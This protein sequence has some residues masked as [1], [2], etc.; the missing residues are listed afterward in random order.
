[1]TVYFSRFWVKYVVKK[2]AHSPIL[3]RLILCHYRNV[4]LHQ[5]ILNRSSRRFHMVDFKWQLIFTVLVFIKS[6]FVNFGHVAKFMHQQRHY[7]VIM[8]RTLMQLENQSFTKI[9]QLLK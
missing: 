8:F 9:T 5:K 6:A 3:C 4:L 1:M 7:W 2:A